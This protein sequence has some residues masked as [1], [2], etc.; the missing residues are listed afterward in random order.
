MPTNGVRQGYPLSMHINHWSPPDIICM[1]SSLRQS[2]TRTSRK[3][4]LRTPNTMLTSIKGLP[5]Q[6]KG[7]NPNSNPTSLSLSPSSSSYHQAGSENTNFL[8]LKTFSGGLGSSNPSV[9][10]SWLSG[11]IRSS[12][13]LA[14]KGIFVVLSNRESRSSLSLSPDARAPNEFMDLDLPNAACP[15]RCSGVLPRMAAGGW[16]SSDGAGR[17]KLAGDFQLP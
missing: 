5:T 1:P 10:S 12:L 4:T 15:K 17:F 8:T 3:D 6:V 2:R 9:S 16:H 14:C 13:P 7:R 11:T